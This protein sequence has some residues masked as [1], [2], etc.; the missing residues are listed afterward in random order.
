MWTTFQGLRGELFSSRLTLG[1]VVLD[2][3]YSDLG[4][5]HQ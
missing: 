4:L 1:G 2:L 3:F 5:G